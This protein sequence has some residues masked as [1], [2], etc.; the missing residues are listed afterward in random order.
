MRYH[1]FSGL[2][3]KESVC[4]EILFPYDDEV[5][6]FKVEQSWENVLA[7]LE[8]AWYKRI[9]KKDWICWE[10][11]ADYKSISYRMWFPNQNIA[12]QVIAKYYSEFPQAEF[13]KIDSEKLEFKGKSHAGTKLKLKRHW[14]LPFKT[15]SD[16]AVDSQS[17]LIAV[18]ESLKEGQKVILQFLIQPVYRTDSTFEKVLDQITE[19]QDEEFEDNRD[20]IY[21]DA[22]S[23][24]RSRN[25]SRVNIK[26][27]AFADNQSEAKV[28]VTG[29]QNAFGTF[30]QKQLN[31]FVARE[32]WQIIQPI[33]RYEFKNRIFSLEKSK[34]KTILSTRELSILLRT[35]SKK[36]SSN[37]LNRMKMKRTPLPKEFEALNA[38]DTGKLYIGDHSYHGVASPVHLPLEGLN[39]HMAIWGG[40]SMGKSTFLVNFCEDLAKVRTDENRVG[41][42]LIDPHGSTAADVVA[43]IPEEQR[44]LVRYVR[45]ADGKFPFNIYKVDF[46]AAPD[47]VAQNIQDVL[48]RVWSDFWGPN[49]DDNFINGGIALQ[50]AGKASIP[51]LQRILEDFKFGAQLLSKFDETKE[52][53]RQLIL[54]FSSLYSM[55]DRDYQQKVGSTL[56]KLR[57][58]TLSETLNSLFSA[59]TNGI[60]WRTG[61]DEGYFT[62]FDL[63]GLTSFEKQLIGSLCLTFSQLAAMS[64][65]DSHRSGEYMPL[66][67]IV[68]DEAPTFMEQSADAIQSF[69]DEARKY[70]VPVVLG[71]QGLEG[72]VPDDV[73]SAIFRNFGFMIAYRV[74]NE[75]DRQNIYRNLQVDYLSADDFK[76]IEPNFAYMRMAVGR[77]TTRPFL[78][79]MKAPTKPYED[80]VAP[81]IE[82]LLVRVLEEEKA[83]REE[84]EALEREEKEEEPDV[85]DSKESAEPEEVEKPKV[86]LDKAND[87][88]K[89]VVETPEQEEMKVK[90]NIEIPIVAT[91]TANI[92]EEEEVD[93]FG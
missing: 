35:P 32:W 55:K 5:K 34:K 49:V 83:F 80:D 47:K 85:F 28:I 11:V 12:N 50:K 14:S 7:V 77:E 71:M 59:H 33:Y 45:F 10:I 43:R 72:Q 30:S 91:E 9:F 54:Y 3:P 19:D 6:Y 82:S 58:I 74:G 15:Y 76:E 92:E 61:M 2:I 13:V 86:N 90:D 29:I 81:V 79:H 38:L 70:N 26:A 68:V 93:V 8:K 62:I 53:D 25:L 27:V 48:K 69:A 51:N 63:S 22:I 73:A 75:V 88:V 39:R 46:Q 67:P 66:H 23:T 24:K 42:T 20:D 64:R 52:L 60:K 89:E 57:K 36:V 44:H 4:Y 37:L 16:D 18:L 87:E 41:F 40:T 56:N 1:L 21:Y 31:S 65:E 84:N 78:V 17:E